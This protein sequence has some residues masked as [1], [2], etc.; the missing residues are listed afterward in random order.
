MTSKRKAVRAVAAGP[1]EITRLI[2]AANRGVTA[3]R[4]ELAAT[5]Y[6]QLRGLAARQLG[7][8]GLGGNQTLSATALVNEVYLKLLRANALS[9]NDRA[10]FFGIAAKAMRQVIVDYFKSKS[11]A[12]RSAPTSALVE[13][14]AIDAGAMRV[15]QLLQIDE[16]LNRLEADNPQ[17]AQVF[18]CRFFTGYGAVE[19]AEIV[20]CSVRTGERLWRQARQTVAAHL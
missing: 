14:L 3:A 12:K 10:H 13:E 7:R 8:S 1:G 19:T 6:G 5:V 17:A 9:A 18:E 11:R 20:G 4:E 16:A 15:D 2:D